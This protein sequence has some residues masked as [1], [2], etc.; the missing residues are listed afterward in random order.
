MKRFLVTTIALTA[1]LSACGNE[2]VNNDVQ[3]NAV[4]VDVAEAPPLDTNTAAALKTAEQQL[5]PQIASLLQLPEAD[6]L[7]TID[8]NTEGTIPAILTTLRVPATANIEAPIIERI[9][10]LL[11]TELST[12]NNTDMHEKNIYI[13]NTNGDVLH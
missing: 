4:K 11:M 9:V 5:L 7:F 8:A 3:Q 10:T 12:I 6:I 2:D 1:L 13:M